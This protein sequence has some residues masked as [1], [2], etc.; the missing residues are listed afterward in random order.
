VFVKNK[1]NFKI[2]LQDS[3]LLLRNGQK[4]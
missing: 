4:N 3:K 1:W 2:S